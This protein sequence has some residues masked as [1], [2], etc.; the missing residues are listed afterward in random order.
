MHISRENQFVDTRVYQPCM[1]LNFSIW[2]GK[3]QSTRCIIPI[4][5][6]SIN[7]LRTFGLKVKTM[8]KG[9]NNSLISSFY[10]D[11]SFVIYLDF[12]FHLIFLYYILITNIFSY[13]IGRRSDEID[14][15]LRSIKLPKQIK[16][17]LKSLK[18]MANFKASEWRTLGLHVGIPILKDILPPRLVF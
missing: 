4:S 18:E 7:C 13:Y 15:R 12:F 14:K 6:S 1:G 2:Y 17:H 16:R 5:V 8:V 10:C 11:F 9:N 3:Y